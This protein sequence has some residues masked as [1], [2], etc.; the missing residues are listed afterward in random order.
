MENKQEL[1]EDVNIDV[2]EVK[3]QME[4]NQMEKNQMDK[5]IFV[6]PFDYSNADNDYY[7]FYTLIG[8][9]SQRFTFPRLETMIGPETVTRVI[10]DIPSS[11]LVPF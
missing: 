11:R 1:N 9:G 3:N 6:P 10:D 8:F 7:V 4:K 5:M 2:P